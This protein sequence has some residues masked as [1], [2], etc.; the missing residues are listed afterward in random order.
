MTSVNYGDTV[1]ITYPVASTTPLIVSAVSSTSHVVASTGT[2]YNG[3]PYMIVDP[4]GGQNRPLTTGN[5]I[6]FRRINEQ[7]PAYW[8]NHSGDDYVQIRTNA[9][10]SDPKALWQVNNLQ[11]SQGQSVTY[12]EQLRLVGSNQNPTYIT[13]NGLGNI[14][15]SGSQ[16]TLPQSIISFLPGGLDT[17]KLECCKN[18]PAL[19]QP[20]FCGDFMGTSCSGE[21][22]SILTQYCASVTTSDPKCGCLLPASYYSQSGM[23]GPAVCIDD[24]CVNT[25]SYRISTQCNP[26]CN[27]VNCSIDLTNVDIESA[28]ISEASFKQYCGFLPPGA[29]PLGPV[30]PTTPTTGGLSRTTWIIIIVSIIILLIIIAILLIVFLR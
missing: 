7:N 30:G 14:I 2:I 20:N 23:I 16:N 12:G 28:N 10:M 3:D 26:N 25:D 27:I 15:V 19:I 13:G 29:P 11:G 18:N 8:Y 21:C 5:N 24:R 22:D 17:A 9:S 1:F 6:A 4:G